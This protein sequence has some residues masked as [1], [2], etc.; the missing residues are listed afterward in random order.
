MILSFYLPWILFRSSLC[1][2]LS[3]R[4]TSLTQA[5]PR[6]RRLLRRWCFSRK[7]ERARV[8]NR[9]IVMI[10]HGVEQ[11]TRFLI[12]SIHQLI[13]RTRVQAPVW[14]EWDHGPLRQQ[15]LFLAL[16][17]CCEIRR[18]HESILGDRGGHVHS[19]Y[20]PLVGTY[21]MMSVFRVIKEAIDFMFGRMQSVDSICGK[22]LEM[23]VGLLCSLEYQIR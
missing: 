10:M 22:I 19:Q 4:H 18:S 20:P 17:W 13:R 6:S 11:S 16:S 23:N 2:P 12:L 5:S 3:Q 9:A 21:H 1:S 15:S 14:M 7:V 8:A